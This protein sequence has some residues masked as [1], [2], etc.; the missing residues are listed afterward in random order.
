MATKVVF[1]APPLTTNKLTAQQRTQLVR[2]A[3]KIEQLLGSTPRLVDTSVRTLGMLLT[4][5]FFTTS[6]SGESK[7][8][9]IFRF[10]LA[11]P[12]ADSPSR[13]SVPSI[14][15][16]PALPPAHS[17]HSHG[18]PH[19]RPNYILLVINVG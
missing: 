7:V 5:K 18:Q 8:L 9:L 10:H 1:P 14:L 13:A 19:L 2:K 12:S 15:H 3:R 6:S 16:H 4:N 17:L 11:L